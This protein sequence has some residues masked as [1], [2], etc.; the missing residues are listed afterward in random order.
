MPVSLAERLREFIRREG[1]ITFHDWMKAALYD[2]SGGYYQRADRKRW[3][4]EGDYRTSPERS[5]LFAATFARYFVGLAS[6]FD[7]LAIVECGAGDGSFAAGLLG[8]LRDQFPARFASARYVVYEL[9]D[10]A[11]RRAQ[12]RLSEFGERVQ[13]CSEW[14]RV[15][16]EPGIYFS[17]ELL[18]AFPVHRVTMDEGGLSELYVDVDSD[19]RFVWSTGPL[20][21]QRLA[22]FVTANSIEL[23]QGQTIEVNLAIDDFF[24]AVSAKLERGFVVTVDYGAEAGELYD[25]ALRPD[26]TLRGF[27]RHG[28]VDDLL[29]EPGER[30]LTT[31]VNWTQV[32]AVG[33]KLGLKVLD[34]ASQDRFLLNAGLLD[35][36]QYR[37]DRAESEAEKVSLTT[38]AREMILPGGMAS[39][40]QVLVQVSHGFQR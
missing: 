37:L 19:G 36:L 1:S 9:S 40:F 11:R 35:R 5:E 39:S 4:R 20:S 38:G 13:F 23:A 12:E 16:V 3:G 33:E 25:P 18:D 34:F 2:P 21:T 7:E 30:D 8:T 29:A 22:Q 28:F 26:G 31:S 15:V 32:K 6:G 14:D 10:D 27:S 24:S 17:N